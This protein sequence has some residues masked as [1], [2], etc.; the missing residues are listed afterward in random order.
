MVFL[1]N[2]NKINDMKFALA[3]WIGCAHLLSLP[4]AS[5]LEL[6]VKW[7]ETAISKEVIW[8]GITLAGTSERACGNLQY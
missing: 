7:K 2:K 6:P 8:V 1:N 4:Y 3:G 5:A